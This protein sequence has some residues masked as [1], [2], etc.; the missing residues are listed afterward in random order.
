VQRK[1]NRP[2]ARA[3]PSR[4][5]LCYGSFQRY[6]GKVVAV[7]RPDAWSSLPNTLKYFDYNFLVKYQIGMKSA[8][9][10]T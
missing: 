2:D 1:C 3:T 9:L 7:D 8:S 5:Y 10:E 4:H 6:F